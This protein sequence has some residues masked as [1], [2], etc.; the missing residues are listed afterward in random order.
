MEKELVCG[1][2]FG[3]SNT[4]ILLGDDGRP[5]RNELPVS[6]S[7]TIPSLIF[8]PE[9]R[10]NVFYTGKEAM[11]EYSREGAKGRF[12]QSIKSVAGDGDI[13]E[14]NVFGKWY[15]IAELISLILKS[16]KASLEEELD[17]N[18]T[19]VV[20][21]RPVLFAHSSGSDRIATERL[22]E[23][24]TMAGFKNIEFELEP[25]AAAYIYERR[26]SSEELVLVVDIGGGTSDF[27]VARLGPNCISHPDRKQDILA[28][29]GLDKGGNN[30][31][32]RVLWA[33]GVRHFGY[34]STYRNWNKTL[35]VPTHIYLELCS[36]EM[37]PFLK[38]NQLIT[39]L[40]SIV[41]FSESPQKILSLIEVIS[42][43]RGFS[44]FRACEEAKIAA[45]DEGLGVLR[46]S[47]E[48]D[49]WEEVLSRD[50]LD[51]ATNE[52]VS[53]IWKTAEDSLMDAGVPKEQ[54]SRV[55]LTG[56]ASLMGSVR[57]IFS[58]EMGE[59]KI[60]GGDAFLSVAK[61]LALSA[62]S[63]FR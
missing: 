56:G 35:D 11:S 59:S 15:T 49:A 8:F 6:T 36:L 43:N 58:S 32:G 7:K 34:G 27:T 22:T 42:K 24:A 29:S 60:E 63:R 12:F 40:K 16:A 33:K 3:T 1:L 31:D 14:T 13:S 23:A 20:L 46:Y 30:F 48:S 50:E 19:N 38:S 53:Q 2:D 47:G 61:G 39:F 52:V 4:C 28:V 9:G 17:Q 18:V 51:S 5:V 37:F 10:P 44:L 55:F 57:R 54:I 25:I 45:N 21:G 26:L 41:A 62:Q